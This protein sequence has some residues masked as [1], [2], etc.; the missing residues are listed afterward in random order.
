M[1]RI[2]KAND[3]EAILSYINTPFL[4]SEN[5]TLNSL[6]NTKSVEDIRK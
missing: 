4:K 5:K 1:L 3:F 2:K 6:K